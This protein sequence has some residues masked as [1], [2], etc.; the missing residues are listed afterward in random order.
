MENPIAIST[1]NDFIFCP[2][3]IYFHMVEG[4]AA[5][6]TYQSAAQLNG[7]AAHENSDAGTY[8]TKKDVLQAISVF[9]E[10]YNLYGKIDTFDIGTGILTERKRK[11]SNIYDG[12]IFQLYAQYFGLEELGYAVNELRLYSM[13]DNRVYPIPKP[14]DSPEML[15]KFEETLK[16][17]QKFSLNSFKQSNLAK[18]QNCIYEP[19]CSCSL[20]K[21]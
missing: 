17:M 3:S 15:L 13:I 6:L 10:K 14:G 1:I 8:S 9:S 19:L 7:T 20:I 5:L 12:Y 18:C 2:A 11:I 4:E 16:D 21:V